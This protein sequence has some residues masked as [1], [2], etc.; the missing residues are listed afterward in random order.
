ML[1]SAA[2]RGARWVLACIAGDVGVEIKGM[3]VVD[4]S[5]LSSSLCR[6]LVRNFR[7]DW[8]DVHHV[9]EDLKTR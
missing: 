6:I 5:G 2:R 9:G 8:V 4:G 7:I 3:G 1:V